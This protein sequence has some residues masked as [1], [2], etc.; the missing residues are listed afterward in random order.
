MSTNILV[1]GG[2]IIKIRK[3]ETNDNIIEYSLNEQNI[4]SVITFNCIIT[5]TNTNLGFVKVYFTTEINI[6]SANQCFI[7]NSNNI[8][9]GSDSLNSDGTRPII[10][11]RV[12][13]Y[14]GLID[15]SNNN[16]YSNI[17][18]FNLFVNGIDKINGTIY[19]TDIYAGWIARYNFKGSNI[20][21]MNCSSNGN[22]NQYGGGIIGGYATNGGSLYIIGCSSSGEIGS[23]AGG[24]TGVLSGIIAGKGI[25]DSCWSSGSIMGVNA[26][27]IVGK[28]SYNFQINN[29]YST[30]NI[31]GIGASGIIGSNSDLSVIR[32]C[33]STGNIIGKESGGISGPLNYICEITVENCYTT[34][35]IYT[36]VSGNLNNAGGIL[37]KILDN[38]QIGTERRRIINCYVAGKIIGTINNGYIIGNEPYGGNENVSNNK[39]II[40]DCYSEAY[41]GSYGWKDLNAN[42]KVSQ[43][44]VLTNV[45]LGTPISSPGFGDSW[46]S[47]YKDI[48]YRISNMGYTPYSNKII[49][50][51]TI[52]NKYNLIRTYS[53]SV[54]QD[55]FSSGAIKN[56]LSY[57]ILEITGGDTNSYN[58]ISINANNGVI[59]T[60]LS[61]SPGTYTIYINN[62]SDTDTIDPLYF[63]TYKLTVN[64]TTK[65]L[66]TS[67]IYMK[68]LF[69]DN[70]LVYYKPHSLSCGG[71][72]T[73]KN[74]KSK[75]HKT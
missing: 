74:Y 50:K 30:G 38:S 52:T 27:G 47:T 58:S 49:D 40:T 19:S 68:N 54:L 44:G 36:G 55:E 34:G 13:N 9:F 12:N 43:T 66:I 70:S 63:T 28:S 1:D 15:N 11:I 51:D 31:L 41:N 20:Y 72:G 14:L 29:C 62:K 35:D 53:S 4:W 33:Y 45:L 39:F 22:I 67:I 10:N 71:I 57:K 17:L 8:Q 21:I 32:N 5:N 56:F 65:P 42:R 48:P 26:G 2:T 46:V 75:C 23:D 61:T 64:K 3:N 59:T 16:K 7:C 60:S 24:I 18:I 37:G 25:I 6:T 69:T 73:V